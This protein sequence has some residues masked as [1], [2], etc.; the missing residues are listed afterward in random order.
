MNKAQLSDLIVAKAK[1]VV[2]KANLLFPK[3]QIDFSA[4]TFDFAMRGKTA[5]KADCKNLVLYYNLIIAG[6]NLTEFLN[7]TVAHEIAHL[8][9]R[10]MYPTSKPHGVEWKLVMMKL[11]Y[12]PTR[13]HHMDTQSVAKVVHKTVHVYKCNC[14]EHNMSNLKHKKIVAGRGYSCTKCKSRLVYVKTI[15]N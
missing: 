13:C 10:K 6:D 7:D 1:E 8:F 14:M 3:N 15:Y 5:G 9:Q 4:I 2:G 11:G 12:E